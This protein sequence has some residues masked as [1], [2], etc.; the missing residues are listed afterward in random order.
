MWGVVYSPVL[1]AGMEPV[2]GEVGDI[3][4]VASLVQCIVLRNEDN[5]LD[6]VLKKLHNCGRCDIVEPY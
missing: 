3:R 6:L 1:V 5:R 2:P 4:V